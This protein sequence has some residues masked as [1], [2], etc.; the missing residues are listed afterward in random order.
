MRIKSTILKDFREKANLSQSDIA[1]KLG[2][3]QQRISA[4]ETG[5]TDVSIW[6]FMQI[7]QI[8]G[9]PTENFWML[10]V[11][12]NEYEAYRKYR[13]LNRLLRDDTQ[14]DKA[15]KLL[16]YFEK[17]KLAKEPFIKQ[18][19]AYAKIVTNEEMKA[20]QAIFELEETI[21]ITFK[22]YDES[23]VN[24]KHMTYHEIKI[25]TEIAFKL[26]QLGEHDRGIALLKAILEG[27]EN[28][29]TTEDDKRI[30]FPSLMY[31][32]AGF[33][34]EAERMEEAIETS[35]ETLKICKKYKSYK[36]VPWI[37]YNIACCQRALGEEE[38]LYKNHLQLAYYCARAHGDNQSATIIKKDAEESFNIFLQ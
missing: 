8:I 13:E 17:K 16:P 38:Y 35:N 36:S 26:N 4:I 14:L 33:L 3:T 30:L 28:A 29:K 2:A 7:M 25:A 23:Q 6:E 19:I 11:E 18:F 24:G 21:K 27:R 12:T 31:N 10:Y 32:L 5:A 37:H 15:R 20:E 9:Q 1:E 22:D 34:R